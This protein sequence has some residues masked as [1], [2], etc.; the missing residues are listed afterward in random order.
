[1]TETPLNS[2]ES[3][4]KSVQPLFICLGVPKAATTWIHRQLEAHPE[5]GCTFSK[6]I[7]FWSSNFD[8]GFE[9]Y[10]HQFPHDRAYNAYAEVSVGYL[11]DDT[12]LDRIARHAPNARMMVSLRNPY[13]R[14]WSSYWNNIRTGTHKG[15]LSAAIQD[16][17]QLL[18]DTRY[19]D[20]VVSYLNRFSP[21]T[22]HVALY[23]DLG[24]DPQ[25]FVRKIYEF[26]GV[27]AAFVPDQLLEP[28]NVGRQHSWMDETLNR[29]QH[30]VKHLGLTRKHLLKMR[31]WPVVE[32]TYGWLGRRH[33]VP[34][35]TEQD[36]AILD[37]HLRPEILR[38]QDILHR[39]LSRWLPA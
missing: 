12:S 32:K 29:T 6:E 26:A 27:D 10:A 5:V 23:D 1:M 17:P 24:E 35:M 3:A 11:G 13:E 37:S 39:D 34:P 38:L 18:E 9:W 15:P 22:L 2:S 36:I 8:K 7:N 28:I 19:S 31:L 21:E 16:L 33:P 25:A 14:A 30:M 4:L 20:G